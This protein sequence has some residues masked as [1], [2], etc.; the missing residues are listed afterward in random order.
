MRIR[1]LPTIFGIIALLAAALFSAG[2]S[3][4]QPTTIEKGAADSWLASHKLEGLDGREVVTRLDKT[5]VKDRPD[6]LMASVQAD[7]V[8]L[9]DADGNKTAV[10]LPEEEF[11]VSIAPY[12]DQTH[13]CMFHSL[14][15]CLGELRNEPVRVTVT[16]ADGTEIVD[17]KRRTY[18][19]GF[20]G[21]WLPRGIDATLKVEHD[22]RTASTAISTADD[23]FTCLTTLR[24]A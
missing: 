5:A 12:V 23:A 16:D 7:A 24:L 6:G 1:A 9:S 15:T 3:S 17:E 18:D 11:Y 19:N 4:S 2:C 20:I 13:D 14:T 10:D 8:L 22:G 21:L